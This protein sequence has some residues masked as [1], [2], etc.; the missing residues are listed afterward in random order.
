MCYHAAMSLGD[1]HPRKWRTLWRA[2]IW[3]GVSLLWCAAAL[4]LGELGAGM[5]EKHR[6]QASPWIQAERNGT[7]PPTPP[8]PENGAGRPF[9]PANHVLTVDAAG[10]LRAD[11]TMTPP[12]PQEHW[13]VSYP[14]D[15]SL[16]ARKVRAKAYGAL[17]GDETR[18]EFC[19]THAELAVSVNAEGN[20]FHVSGD[21]WMATLLRHSLRHPSDEAWLPGR[22]ADL[23]GYFRELAA[24]ARAAAEPVDSSSAGLTPPDFPAPD[25]AAAPLPAFE[26][27][28]AAFVFLNV[29]APLLPMDVALPEDTPW[30]TPWFR[31]KKH[32][33]G[34]RGASRGM[35]LDTNNFGY[36]DRDFAVPKPEGVFRILCV[37]GSTTE[38][39][40]T[41][42]TTY[43]ALLEQ[44]LRERLP[45]VE[46]EVFNC[47]ISGTCTAFQLSKA[48]E[49]LH[50]DPDVVVLYEGVNDVFQLLPLL[51]ETTEKHAFRT[52]LR[53]S[54]LAR[55]TAP[56]SVLPET[57]R[58][59]VE[60][61]PVA[62]LRLL[63]RVLASHGVSILVCG[64]AAPGPAL[65]AAD[66][67]WFD[68]DAAAHWQNTW[69]NWAAARRTVDLLNEG[70]ESLC[71]SEGWRW[72]P[73]HEQITGGTGVFRDLCHLH[74]HAI[75]WKAEIIADALVAAGGTARR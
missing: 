6:Q 4:I 49:F 2:T 19:R 75:R 17:L 47:G 9:V 53:R 70:L 13:E 40:E 10:K 63:G 66:R 8:S 41:G 25:V 54:R 59:D 37:G 42:Q 7:E 73:V 72:V 46:V 39:G 33:T 12:P 52:L 11:R 45:G 31:Y 27:T 67:V 74:Q 34:S 43:P 24:A 51:W 23:A 62:N 68:Y 20:V 14:P 21:Y 30:E 56:L 61:L 60:R 16:E 48:A 64:A 44:I 15:M 71:H 69:M 65:D 1:E 55:L 57:A 5:L 32:L 36:R 18:D 58:M 29:Y 28:A 22:P 3:G 26:K 50:L 38:E 35:V